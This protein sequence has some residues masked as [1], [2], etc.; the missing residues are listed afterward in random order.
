MAVHTSFNK[1]TIESLKENI[2]IINYCLNF[3][4]AKNKNWNGESKEGCLGVPALI[5]I[6]TLIDTIG[7]YFRGAEYII[8]ID[9]ENHKIKFASDH[10]YVLNHDKFFNLG[11][12]MA[13][14]MDF[15]S[16]YRSKLV[17][18]TT[19]PENNFL[20]IGKKEDSIFQLDRNNKIIKINILPLFE[21]TKVASD[22][23]IYYLDNG[24][25]SA[26]HAVKKELIA[27]SKEYDP[28]NV[29]IIT[30]AA[31]GFTNTKI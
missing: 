14:I 13:T 4:K 28:L 22:D 3:D 15:Y 17:H 1:L 9:E 7:S 11:L 5:L 6:C 19:L 29:P 10:F 25:F 20:E 18:N 16:T 23:F 21:K 2:F 30:T 12:K 26:D 31:T 24:T 27:K 8:S